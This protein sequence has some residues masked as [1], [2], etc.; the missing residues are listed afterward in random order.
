MFQIRRIVRVVAL[1]VTVSA[2]SPDAQPPAEPPETKFE[3]LADNYA[4][5]R[6][7][8]G[9]V[10][11]AR[12]GEILFEKSYGDAVLEWDIPI[13]PDTKYRIAS[14]SKPFLATLIMRLVQDDVLTL[15]DTLGQH[16]PDLYAN[17]LVADVTVAELLAHTSGMMDLPRDL[18]SDFYK[19]TARLEADPKSNMQ[20]YIKPE[21]ASDRGIWRYNNAGY[22]LLGLIVESATDRPFNDVINEKILAPAGMTSTAMFENNA[23]IDRLAHAYIKSPNGNLIPAPFIDP[24]VFFT[25][26]GLYSTARDIFR[27]DRALYTTDI[28]SADSRSYMHTAKTDFAYGAGWGVESWPLSDGNSV[29]VVHHTGS[30]PGYQSFYIRS[31]PKQDFVLVFNNTNNGSATVNLGRDMMLMLNGEIIKRRLEDLVVPASD[32]GGV[33]AVIAAYEGLGDKKA[34]YDLSEP[35]VNRLGYKL[36][37]MEKLDEA[38]AVFEWNVENYPDSANPRDSL[39][40][41]YRTA[42]RID[43]AIASYQA[44]LD[45]DPSSESAKNAIASMRAE[46]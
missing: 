21:F 4:E 44:A 6:A 15:E 29:P 22:I 20:D 46:P 25:A 11:V 27:F 28:L 30:M 33:D 32:E 34:D 45:R 3:I 5:N 36:M 17:T 10:M 9:T 13:T 37:G 40:E 35:S 26:A 39:G 12:G 1:C 24:S 42:G 7:F 2:C 14:L 16:F 8:N 38:I 31:E 23:L 18:L 41:A 19:S 43:E